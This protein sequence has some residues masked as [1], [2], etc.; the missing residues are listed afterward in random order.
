LN[1]DYV[2]AIIN[3][4]VPVP[5]TEESIESTKKKVLKGVSRYTE[6]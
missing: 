6:L 1:N 3:D 2:E 4:E 5:T